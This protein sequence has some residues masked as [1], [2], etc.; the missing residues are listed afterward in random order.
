MIAAYDAQGGGFRRPAGGGIHR[1]AVVGRL[2]GT[3]STMSIPAIRRPHVH[4]QHG[5]HQGA[6]ARARDHV[7]ATTAD[8]SILGYTNA[9]TPRSCARQSSA[10]PAASPRPTSPRS[11]SPCAATST[12][13]AAAATSAPSTSPSSVSPAFCP[14]SLCPRCPVSR[15]R[16][17]A[18]AVEMSHRLWIECVAGGSP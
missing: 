10:T 13:T 7:L 17:D 8:R 16:R 11:T 5:A 1:V 3:R 12:S 18:V 15:M 9:V 2:S 4:C 6:Q 14:H